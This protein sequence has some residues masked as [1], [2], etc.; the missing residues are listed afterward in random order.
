M[1][2]VLQ[3]LPHPPTFLV[4]NGSPKVTCLLQPSFLSSAPVPSPPPPLLQEA[5]LGSDLSVHPFVLLTVCHLYCNF[6]PCLNSLLGLLA[7]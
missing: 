4:S 5:F 3:R 6:C 1:G 7:S 2:M